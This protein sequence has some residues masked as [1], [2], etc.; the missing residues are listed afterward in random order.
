MRATPFL[1]SSLLCVATAHA[2]IA[3]IAQDP[4]TGHVYEKVDV[5]QGI[6][7]QDARR[8]AES[9]SHNGV[10]GH[11]ATI[12][13]TGEQRFLAR[14]FYGYTRE[15]WL[16][17]YQVE[18]NQA[19]GVGWR[20]I[21]GEAWNFQN[22]NPG[23]PNDVNG[24]SEGALEMYGGGQPEPAGSWNDDSYGAVNVGYIVE[25]E[26]VSRTPQTPGNPGAPGVAPS[27]TSAPRVR[28]LYP[29][30][31][32]PWGQLVEAVIDA[33]DAGSGVGVSGVSL[34]LYS[35]LR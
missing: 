19:S 24:I 15:M 8:V 25:Y 23:E 11:L 3:Q 10:R 28:I 31:R 13:S 26:R 32:G 35:T 5:P 1:V 9:R 14:A 33:Q 7:W 22:W 16:G 29:M 27:D 21:T 12:T 2:Q 18:G 30:G 20:W 34:A 4:Q 17:G 6:T